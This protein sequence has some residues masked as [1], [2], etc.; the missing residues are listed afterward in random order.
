[1]SPP[2][3]QLQRLRQRWRYLVRDVAPESLRP[4]A[5]IAVV[6]LRLLY[7]VA[8]DLAEGQLTLRAMSLV[9]TTLLSIVPLLAVSFSVLKAFGVHNQI[10]PVLAGFLA[11]LGPK[12]EE[13]TA[14]IIGFVENVQ[15]GVLGS[16]GLALLLYVVLSLIQKIERALNYTWRI[17]RLRPLRLRVSGYLSVLLVGPVL[18]FSAIGLMASIRAHFVV[19]RIL[20]IE[21]FGT[22]AYWTGQIAPYLLVIATFTIV[23]MLIPN[24]RVRLRSAL[25]GGAVAGVLWKVLAWAFTTFAISSTRYAAIY[26]GFAIL[27]LFMIW[28]YLN[29]L[30]LLIG[31]QVAY[32][33]QHPQAIHADGPP[34]CPGACFIERLA[35]LVMALLGAHFYHGGR[36]WTAEAL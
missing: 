9:Y 10:E 6:A 28:L 15:V 34:R 16:L 21:P 11:P 27:L 24:T 3:Q 33:H 23:Y 12:G 31:A 32:Y 30:T 36:P 20:A 29:W 14:R 35:L 19:E 5:R 25:V 2:V 26:S 7:A 17:R 1:M 4:A 22:L 13:I 8:R 18:M